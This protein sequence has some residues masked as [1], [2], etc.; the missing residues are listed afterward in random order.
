[1]FYHLAMRLGGGALAVVIPLDGPRLGLDR[2]RRTLACVAPTHPLLYAAIRPCPEHPTL[3]RWCPGAEMPPT[4]ALF[5]CREDTSG[6][7]FIAAMEQC[8]G[9]RY[10]VAD[11]CV[12]IHCT[13]LRCPAGAE[14]HDC[15]LF[16]T[17]HL[18]FDGDGFHMWLKRLLSTLSTDAPAV[19]GTVATPLMVPPSDYEMSFTLW[20]QRMGDTPLPPPRF[21]S[22]ASS[23]PVLAPPASRLSRLLPPLAVVARFLPAPFIAWLVGRGIHTI[24]LDSSQ[25][26]AFLAACKAH[27]VGPT[28][29]L[30]GAFGRAIRDAGSSETIPYVPVIPINLRSRL[31]AENEDM[32]LSMANGIIGFFTELDV[33]LRATAWEIA[34][35][36]QARFREDLWLE[37]HMANWTWARQWI[38]RNDVLRWPY[39]L[40]CSVFVSNVGV[41]DF[42]INDPANTWQARHLFVAGFEQSFTI[43]SSTINGRL[44][45][46]VSHPVAIWSRKTGAGVTAAIRAFLLA[47]KPAA[48]E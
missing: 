6:K 31:G 26:L 16:G 20:A 18:F 46:T 8:L 33:S 32:R 27:A 37:A 41:V 38:E 12:R 30:V 22:C 23:T 44:A 29:A 48:L 7:P 15:L 1:M 13:L 34:T 25:T 36:W 5:T 11:N 43:L 10:T 3:A 28:A 14:G 17:H 19:P 2:L 24:T 40:E 39:P 42:A 45:V 47:A 4:R 9:I 21:T 35:T